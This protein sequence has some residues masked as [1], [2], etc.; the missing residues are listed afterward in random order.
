MVT[1]TPARCGPGARLCVYSGGRCLTSHIQGVC[2]CVQV[3]IYMGFLRLSNSG[4]QKL[5]LY[6]L[7]K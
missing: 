4:Y 3:Y 7:N 2:V 5:K 6:L 1:H